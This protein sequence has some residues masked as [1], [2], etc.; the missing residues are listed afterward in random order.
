MDEG[1]SPR[2]FTTTIFLHPLAPELAIV[3]FPSTPAV[4]S[5]APQDATSNDASAAAAE[6]LYELVKREGGEW[7][8]YASSSPRLTTSLLAREMI[9]RLLVDVIDRRAIS[10]VP[11]PFDG[12]YDFVF[13]QTVDL[14]DQP[15]P[16]M[17][18]PISGATL[19]QLFATTGSGAAFL[20]YFP[21]PDGAQIATFF[22]LSAG[23]RLSLVR[24]TVS[25]TH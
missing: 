25:V 7:G 15:I 3:T 13:S 12:R 9:V 21:H 1:L 18:S 22:V 2:F 20:A 11:D 5:N 8:A 6:A 10:R 23:Q 4:C 14:L 19:A 17:N 24:R 16:V